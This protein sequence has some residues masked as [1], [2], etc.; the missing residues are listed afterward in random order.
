LTFSIMLTSHRPLLIKNISFPI[1]PCCAH[2][3]NC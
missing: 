1:P 3:T 2:Q